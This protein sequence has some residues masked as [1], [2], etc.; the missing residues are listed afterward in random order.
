MENNNLVILS[1]KLE[2]GWDY[3]YERKFRWGE[4]LGGIITVYIVL[5]LNILSHKVSGSSCAAYPVQ[6]VLMQ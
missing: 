1:G 4:N 5:K 2:F 3:M 6:Q